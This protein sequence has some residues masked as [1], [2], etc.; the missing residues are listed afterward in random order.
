MQEAFGFVFCRLSLFCF[1]F[2][3]VFYVFLSLFSSALFLFLSSQSMRSQ[4]LDIENVES[5][6]TF[7]FFFLDISEHSDSFYVL[8]CF[9]LQNRKRALFFHH[10]HSFKACFPCGSCRSEV[11]VAVH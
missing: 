7:F 5:G 4:S 3:D 1:H 2:V 9:T 10:K 6:V 11:Q 8:D